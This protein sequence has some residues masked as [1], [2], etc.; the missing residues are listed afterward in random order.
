MTN[1]MTST[2][3]RPAFDRPLPPISA[4]LFRLTLR[5]LQWEERRQTRRSLGALDD[6]MLN[7][8][9]IPRHLARQE[10]DKPFWRD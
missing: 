1:M 4:L 5:V 2:R 8:I 7:D 6:H 3:T 9:G 10:S